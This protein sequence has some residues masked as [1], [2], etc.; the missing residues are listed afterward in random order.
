M[1][2]VAEMMKDVQVPLVHLKTGDKIPS[3]TITSTPLTKRPT[4]NIAFVKEGTRVTSTVTRPTSST[5]MTSTTI[6]KPSTSSLKTVPG[7][8]SET[9]TI[10]DDDMSIEEL[11][12]ILG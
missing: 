12:E 4:K 7:N 9:V 11:Q 1:K 5:I 2:R 10:P 6:S 3:K 8:T